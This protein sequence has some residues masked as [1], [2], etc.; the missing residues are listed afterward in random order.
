MPQGKVRLVYRHF[1]FLG[2]ESVLA[3]SASDC[4]AEQGM[5]WPYHHKLYA[6]QA[7]RDRGTFSKENLKRFAAEVGLDAASFNACVDS[8][9]YVEQVRAET[10]EG[11]RRGVQA[12]PTLF[13][14]GQKIEGVPDF[15]QLRRIIEAAAGG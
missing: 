15:N 11:R 1:A 4:A 2:P 6:E 3:A 5:F 7:G 13:V 9:R 12:T 8:D 10:E 14:N